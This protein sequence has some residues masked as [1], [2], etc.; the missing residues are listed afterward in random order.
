MSLIR[1]ENVSLARQ[2][3]TLLSNLTGQLKKDRP[4]LSLDLTVQENQHFYAY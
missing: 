2:G 4:G 3:K 1:L